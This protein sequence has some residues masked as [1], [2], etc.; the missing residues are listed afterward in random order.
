MQEKKKT[1]DKIQ[2]LSMIKIFYK[3]DIEGTFLN[4]I[5]I[6]CD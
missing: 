6:I 1:S 2:Q 4:I 5:K 3:G